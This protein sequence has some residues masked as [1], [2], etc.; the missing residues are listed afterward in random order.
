MSIFLALR[1]IL[2]DIP[3]RLATFSATRKCCQ[4]VAKRIKRG[5]PLMPRKLSD[6]YLQSLRKQPK[7][8]AWLADTDSETPG[9]MV[10][11]HPTG[12]LTLGLWAQY[13]GKKARSFRGIGQYPELS[14]AQ[15]RATA[16]EW[17]ELLRKGIDPEAEQ[18]RQ[19]QVQLRAQ[20]VTFERVL[21]DFAKAA[22]ARQRRGR[23]VEREVRRNFAAWLARPVTS[24]DHHD[25]RT[26]ITAIVSRG[27][28]WE[29]RNAYGGGKALYEWAKSTGSFG[30]EV[31]PFTQVKLRALVGEEFAPRSR[32]LS[33]DEIAAFWRATGRMSHPWQGVLRLLALSGTRLREAA[34]SAW[35][36]FD[37]AEALWRI[38]PERF[39]SGKSGAGHVVPITPD[40]AKLLKGLPRFAGG[41]YLFSLNGGRTPVTTFSKAKIQLDKLMAEELGRKVEPWVLHDLRRVLRTALASL[42]IPD[43]VAEMCLGHAARG[44]RR[45]YDQH[46]YIDEVRSALIAWNARLRDITTPPPDNVVKLEA[47]AAG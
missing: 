30:V 44:L 40:I 33:N 46:K 34:D 15:A 45:I 26:V 4:I 8:E 13:P 5:E 17:R 42:Q 35:V 10:R 29:A 12:R 23:S 28:I 2:P 39:K 20:A 47:K 37:F 3:R 21:E 41:D 43:H 36:E 1:V 24:I 32:V 31:N 19:R 38:P 11:V 22:L 6:R 27:T 16:R 14:L 9:L 7:A 18:E 25:V